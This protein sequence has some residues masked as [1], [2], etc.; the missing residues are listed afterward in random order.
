MEDREKFAYMAGIIDG[1]GC[2]TFIPRARYLERG[3]LS[4]RLIIT[5]TDKILVDWLTKE[6]GGS[7][8]ICKKGQIQGKIVRKLDYFYWYLSTRKAV[9]IIKECY[10]Y[11]TIKKLQADLILE[12]IKTI[13]STTKLIPQDV[14]EK[15]LDIFQKLRRLKS[16]KGIR[17]LT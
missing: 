7:I 5:T 3:G 6:F 17:S 1:E 4:V 8:S 15:R 14:V 12:F 2:I 10:P 13:Q 16:G 9:E 11:L